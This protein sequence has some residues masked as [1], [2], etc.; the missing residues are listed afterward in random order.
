MS[1]IEIT[2]EQAI[3]MLNIINYFEGQ[4]DCLDKNE[5]VLKRY[6]E[7]EIQPKPTLSQAIGIDWVVGCIFKTTGYFSDGDGG[8]G[9]YIV[10]LAGTS[11][12]DGTS[13]V[14][15]DNGCQA[16]LMYDHTKD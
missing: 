9:E 4:Q 7:N 16:C 14:E 12:I 13:V 2:K 8:A 5:E 15:L 6:L 3:L 11:V 10:Q 1:K